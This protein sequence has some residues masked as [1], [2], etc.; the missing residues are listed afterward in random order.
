MAIEAH[1][2][3]DPAKQPQPALWHRITAGVLKA[4]VPITILAI[5]VPYAYELYLTGPVAERKS[6]PRVP[7]VVEVIE[8]T[9]SLRGPTIE[10]WG[11]VVPARTLMLRPEIPGVITGINPNMTAGG[12]IVAG[13]TLLQIDE[14]ATRLAV[15]QAEADIAE[16]QARIA[17]ER[18]QGQRAQ[19]DA[20]RS[21]ISLTEEQRSLVLREPQ[22][23]QLEA[24]LAAAEAIREQAFLDLSK[25][26]I[27]APFGSLVMQEEVAAGTSVTT[28]S[29]L[30]TLVSTESFHVNVAVPVGA[31][32]WLDLEEKGRVRLTQP[33]VW[34][35]GVWREGRIVRRN[36]TLSETGRMVEIIVEVLDPMN[37]TVIN[38][39]QPKLIL[40]S[41][42]R[43]EFEGRAVENAVELDRNYLRENGEVW[44]MTPDE[45][46]DIREVDI[47][48][49]G[50][51]RV[52]VSG[53]LNPGDKVVTT[54]LAISAP[55][56]KLRLAEPE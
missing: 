30:A 47:A 16:I 44:V 41:F 26:R 20:D 22:M 14:R 23:L 45:T 52:L 51:E 48:W 15:A 12:E 49:R 55:G 10:A 13:D 19:R 53:G 1:Q 32:R 2:S 28:G 24:E 33:E 29:D 34:S 5:A 56:M 43:A 27:A 36:A 39:E 18:G 3:Y 17:I 42:L 54:N 31:L 46:L 7:R 9:P 38:R 37:H 8:V 4:L 35:T 6:R 40:G 11:E 50:A 25:T 21:G